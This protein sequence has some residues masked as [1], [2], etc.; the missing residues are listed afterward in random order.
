[1]PSIRSILWKAPVVIGALVVGGVATNQAGW[2]GAE[3]V[4]ERVFWTVRILAI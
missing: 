3:S 2:S 1:M 4:A